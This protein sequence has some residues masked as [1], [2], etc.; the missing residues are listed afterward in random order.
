MSVWAGLLGREVEGGPFCGERPRATEMEFG[1]LR[2][3][4]RG[5]EPTW[6]GWTWTKRVFGHF[7]TLV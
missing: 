7:S 1:W 4:V 3:F 6:Y 2:P 5:Q